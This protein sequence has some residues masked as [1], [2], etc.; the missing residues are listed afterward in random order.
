MNLPAIKHFDDLLR[1]TRVLA[2]LTC[3]AAES[4]KAVVLYCLNPL[5][6]AVLKQLTRQQLADALPRGWMT[7]GPESIS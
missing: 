6:Q 7:P 4:H 2:V 1:A 3:P 5:E